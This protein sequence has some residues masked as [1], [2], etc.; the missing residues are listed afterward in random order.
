MKPRYFFPRLLHWQFRLDITVLRKPYAD[1]T[2]LEKLASSWNKAQGFYRRREWS[3]VV[4]R[5][6]TAAEISANIAVRS[7]LELERKLETAFVDSLLKWANGLDGK[8]NRLLL[9]L[10]AKKEKKDTLRKLR[11][12][13]QDINKNRNEVVHSGHFMNE[14]EATEALS[15]CR[16]F[17][18]TLVGLYHL[19]YSVDDAAKQLRSSKVD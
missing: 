6:A 10:P 9:Q 14:D 11:L 5:A 7:E 12:K 16:E 17:I 8:M 15:A 3:A 18:N 13:A 19:H 4:T 2:D 1:R